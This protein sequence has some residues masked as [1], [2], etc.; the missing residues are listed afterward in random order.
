MNKITWQQLGLIF[1]GQFGVTAGEAS[2]I[3]SKEI[4]SHNWKHGAGGKVGRMWHDGDVIASFTHVLEDE[5]KLVKIVGRKR[6]SKELF[7]NSDKLK[8]FLLIANLRY[9]ATGAGFK[10]FKNDY[11][12]WKR[13]KVFKNVWKRGSKTLRKLRK[14]T[15]AKR[16]K[17]EKILKDQNIMMEHGQK[18]T[19]DLIDSGKYEKVASM[20]GGYTLR[21]IQD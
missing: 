20:Y 4:F 2:K 12:K 14:R 21:K 15:A 11:A 10:T 8:L 18:K 19:K 16:R 9:K 17:Y 5:D 13:I 1:E 6:A 7:F 3:I